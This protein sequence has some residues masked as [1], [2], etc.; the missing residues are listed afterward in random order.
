[1]H[2]LDASGART[3]LKIDL[4]QR[5]SVEE[6]LRALRLGMNVTVQDPSGARSTASR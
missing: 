4:Q 2:V 3:R 6:L 1:M 5:E